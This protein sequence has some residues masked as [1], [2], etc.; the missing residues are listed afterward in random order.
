MLLFSSFLF[1]FQP[2]RTRMSLFHALSLWSLTS[3]DYST[4]LYS[5]PSPIL[6]FSTDDTE[7]GPAAASGAGEASSWTACVMTPNSKQAF[8]ATG[9]PQQNQQNHQIQSQTEG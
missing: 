2:K 3:D 6:L 7:D 5:S 1:C 9:S 4:H 8:R